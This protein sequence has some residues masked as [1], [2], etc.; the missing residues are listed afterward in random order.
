MTTTNPN[1][2]VRH[3]H[4]VP[5]AVA[6]VERT[7][8]A[9]NTLTPELAQKLAAINSVSRSLRKAGVRVEAT[10]VLDVTIFIAAETADF[11]AVVFRQQWQGA[12]WRTSGSQTRNMVTIQG[13]RVVWFTPVK[14]QDQ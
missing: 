1:A 12:C 6:P 10:V 11:L 7:L 2:P 5:D 14:E 8:P 13:V 9:C 4:L 3:L